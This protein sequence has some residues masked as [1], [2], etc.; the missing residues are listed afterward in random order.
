MLGHPKLLLEKGYLAINEKFHK[1]IIS[2]RTDVAVENALDKEETS[3][4]DLSD[5]HWE[6]Y[7][8]RG[9]VTVAS[10]QENDVAQDSVYDPIARPEMKVELDREH[11]LSIVLSQCLF[12]NSS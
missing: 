9:A 1:L 2:L 11:N 3:Y 6:Y 12:C 7:Q 5:W 4:N 10:N 8:V